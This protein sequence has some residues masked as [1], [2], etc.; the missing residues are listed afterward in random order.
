M[1]IG[2]K[3]GVGFGLLI[4]ISIT[5]GGMAVINMSNISR[6]SKRLAEEYVPQVDISNELERNS[7]LTMYN[8]RGY[9]LTGEDNFLNTGRDYLSQAKGSLRNAKDLSNRTSS[10]KLLEEGIDDTESTIKSYELLVDETKKVND[11]MAI[12]LNNMDDGANQYM[13]SSN[14]YLQNQIKEANREAATG[15]VNRERLLKI[16]LINKII[17]TGNNI[18]VNNFKAQAQRD[19]ELFREA[20]KSFDQI[21]DYLS[22]IRTFTRIDL[23]IEQL[24]NVKEGADAYHQAMDNYLVVWMQRQELAKSRDET[25]KQVLDNAQRLAMAGI[26]Q[27]QNIANNAIDLLSTSNTIMIGGL[28]FALLLGLTF[29]YIITR[30]IT[31][32][33]AK[34]VS[35]AGQ[36]ADGDLT[37]RIEVDQTDEIGD[38]ANALKRMVAKLRNIV[39]EVMTGADN[40]SSASFQMSSTSQQMSQGANEQASSAEEVSSS[41]E[42]MAANIQQNTDNAQQ[43][44]KIALKAADDVLDGSKAV[45]Q[46]V[47]SMKSIADKITIIG[48]IA[49]QTNILALNAAVEAARAGEHGKGFAVVAAEVRKLAERSQ[50]AAAEIDQVSKSSVDI[51]EKSGKLLSEIVPD[52]QKTAKLVQE[53]SAA[54]IEQNSGADQVNSAIQQLNQVTQQNAA[55]SEEMATGSEELASQAEQLMATI[56]YFKVGEETYQKKKKKT[57]NAA[58]ENK[59]KVAHL[60]SEHKETSNGHS[61]GVKINMDDDQDKNFEKF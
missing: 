24:N 27:T 47:E 50:A 42:E 30:A 18:R 11:K 58:P 23:D 44:E 19:N 34:G 48:E 25:G 12:A 43:T 46:T 7:L 29:A 54:S 52:I 22:E 36:I 31:I 13:K 53:I 16:E 9:G 40:I 10:L 37:A 60:R 14:V 41:M 56:T 59:T 2:T 32:P 21:D 1:K 38:L 17:D 57:V 49:R 39:G 33:I 28:I 15:A 61:N 55:A 20:L 8:M 51:A 45:N 5:L 3:L 6:E 4:L 35:F 26:D